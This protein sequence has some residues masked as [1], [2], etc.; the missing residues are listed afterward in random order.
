MLWCVPEELREKDVR[1][2]AVE[3]PRELSEVTEDERQE[4]AGLLVW[5]GSLPYFRDDLDLESWEAEDLRALGELLERLHVSL[6]RID[7][8]AF[9]QYALRDERD[10]SIEITNAQHHE[11]WHRFLD[12]NEIAVLFAAVE[13]AKTQQIAIGRALFALGTNPNRTMAIVS[14]TEAQAK[15]NGTAIMRHVT[16]NPRVHRVFPKLRP[17]PL[18]TDPWSELRFTVERD[19]LSAKEPSVQCLG[20]MGAINGSRLDVL[21]FDDLLDIRNTATREQM[22]KILAWVDTTALTRIRED[23][24]FWWIG[25]PWKRGDPMHTVAARP[26]V[27]KLEHAAVLNPDEPDPKRWIPRWPER[28]SV[29]RLRRQFDRMNPIAFARK[30]LLRIRNDEDSR[31]DLAWIRRAFDF[32]HG[33]AFERRQP[34]VDG[35]LA[36]CWTGVDIGIGRKKRNHRSAVV[37]ICRHGPGRY[38]VVS[39]RSGKWKA[40]E[41]LQIIRDETTRF[42][43]IAY[44]EN[45]Q[46]QDFLVQFAVE[47]EDPLPV[48]GFTTGANKHDPAFG[49][50]ALAVDL[51]NSVLIF[52]GWE[53]EGERDPEMLGLQAD[54]EFYDPQSHTGDRLMGLWFARMASRHGAGRDVARSWTHDFLDR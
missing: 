6:A 30:Y 44:V 48:V 28:W 33:F 51:R 2:G 23:G 35:E 18:P 32:G 17:S 27:A 15:K 13:H 4:L 1:G 45:N 26:G 34:V 20:V 38:R 19:A 25:T 47:G 43:S 11:E 42:N 31:F 50:E 3:L 37:T 9:V 8:A 10:D 22:E 52:P 12:E 41:I 49:V 14:D 21:I 16:E 53:S 40:P 29:A 39:I 54:L 24:V 7:A 5:R 36:P 46:A